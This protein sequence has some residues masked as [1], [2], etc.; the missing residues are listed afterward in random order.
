M[1]N[2]HNRSHHGIQILIK[3][4]VQGVGFRPFVHGLAG[5]LG[6]AGQ[7]RNTS[8][9]VKVRL[10]G[11]AERI[12][13][14]LE[15]LPEEAPEA[16]VIHTIDTDHDPHPLPRDGF[17]ILASQD[18]PAHALISPDLATCDAC[19]A[20]ILDPAD[21]RFAYPF[22]NCT[23]CGPRLT[24]LKK[25]PYDRPNTSMAAFTM[26][27]ACRREYE[28]PENRRF[29]AQPNA[30]PV[31]GP[32]VS[33]HD[34]KG[35]LLTANN[36]KVLATCASALA[37]GKIVA[38][39]GLGGFH[40]AVD[41]TTEKAV[42]RL[43]EKKQRPDK[44]LAVMARDLKCIQQI[45]TLDSLAKKLLNGRERPIVLLP[46]KNVP[47]DEALAPGM[48]VLGVMLPYTPLH[49]L[50]FAQKRCP[51]LLV[52]TSG[53]RSGAPICT[54]NEEAIRELAGMA[55]FFLLHNRDI[56]TRVDDSV[57]R[58][59]AN[60]PRLI[61]RARGYA[62]LPF[63][64][65]GTENSNILACGAE[66]KNTFCL[67]RAATKDGFVCQHIGDLQSI[68][69]LVFYEQ[70]LLYYEQVLRIKPR[71]VVRDL[72]PDYLSSRFADTSG[73]PVLQVQHHHAHAAAVMAEHDLEECLTVVYDGAGLGEDGTIW[74]GEFF[75]IKKGD[76]QRRAH[77][78]PFHLPGGDAATR[79]IWRIALALLADAGLAD[80]AD[81]AALPEL[82]AIEA[83]TKKN[84]LRMLEKDIN[85]P[86]CSS[87]GRLFDGVAA[88]LGIRQTTT[89]EGQAAMELEALA[90]QDKND[91]LG[92]GKNLPDCLALTRDNAM[93]VLD[94]RPMIR[95][96]VAAR[97]AGQDSGE[98][99][100]FFHHWL[101]QI[102]QKTIKQITSQDNLPG[103]SMPIVLAG[104]CFQ[105]QL[106]L[107]TVTTGL[108]QQG[109]RVYSGEKIPVNDGGIAL[110]QAWLAAMRHQK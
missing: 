16:S 91:F 107:E 67:T 47:L 89:F 10:Y 37:D 62:P 85:S 102:T 101:A 75:I 77:L 49:H 95:T 103:K 63:P 79:E 59:A 64:L 69:N 14:F 86:R 97:R 108:Q 73:L 30:C 17:H 56:V 42:T 55:D 15:R 13:T 26:C 90:R 19:L 21:R 33:W 44:P 50:L 109:Y 32:R 31:C 68:D 39:K 8:Q 41:A 48:D 72:H 18:G 99:A 1:H 27:A 74:G 43:R 92:A 88:L 83:T 94:H 51:E 24:I 76:C 20:E 78:R 34:S 110:G 104:G 35:R 53:N 57:V 45:C 9:G 98:M 52:M 12:K 80:M 61:R 70:A 54:G 23:N 60:A 36:E 96:I 58:I 6:L 87:A 29:H 105:N 38:I 81:D 100:L 5:E 3:G 93:L 66:Q 46:K 4:I 82:R 28:D 65:P 7:V 106:L 2:S 84:I 11:P 22:T 25:I 40:L 71:R